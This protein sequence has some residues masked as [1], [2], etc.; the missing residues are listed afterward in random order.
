MFWL[1]QDRLPNREG[2]NHTSTFEN[3]EHYVNVHVKYIYI[4]IYNTYNAHVQ[5]LRISLFFMTSTF[6]LSQNQKKLYALYYII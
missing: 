6:N 5:F 1:Q 3:D 2:N 4:Y